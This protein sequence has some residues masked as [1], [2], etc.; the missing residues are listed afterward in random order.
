MF[1]CFFRFGIFC[2]RKRCKVKNYSL[3]M[4][5]QETFFAQKNRRCAEIRA[6]L[7]IIYRKISLIGLA[8]WLWRC[9]FGATFA[10][11]VSYKNSRGCAITLRLWCT[12]VVKSCDWLLRLAIL[13]P[14]LFPHQVCRNEPVVHLVV[15]CG[16]CVGHAEGDGVAARSDVVERDVLGPNVGAGTPV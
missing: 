13:L 6:L 15:L 16:L 9:I 3:I 8:T 12:L 2:A 10:S 11:E 4:K 7:T 14:D 5:T 1:S